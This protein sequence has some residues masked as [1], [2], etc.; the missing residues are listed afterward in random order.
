M[1]SFHHLLLAFLLLAA[2]FP[3]CKKEG[4]ISASTN[5]LEVDYPGEDFIINV[6]ASSHWTVVANYAPPTREEMMNHKDPVWYSPSGAYSVETGWI[7]PEISEGE[8]GETR[9]T[10]HIDA[11]TGKSRYGSLIFKLTED[12][13]LFILRVYQQGKKDKDMSDYLSPEMAQYLEDTSFGHILGI[14]TLYIR[15]VPFDFSRDL[16][17]FENLEELHCENSGLSAIDIEMPKLR[18]LHIANCKVKR[19]DPV[20]FPVLRDLDCSGNPL[21]SLDILSAPKLQKARCDGVRVKDLSLGPHLDYIT[22]VDCGLE[23]LDLS[24]APNLEDLDCSYN[25]L[26][27]LDISGTKITWL[28]CSYNER[29]SSLILQDECLKILLASHCGL[30]GSYCI[31]AKD[32][33][34]VDLQ[35]NKLEKLIFT[36]GISEGTIKCDNNQ[37]TELILPPVEEMGSWGLTCTNNLLHELGVIDSGQF[38][39]KGSDVTLNPGKDGIFKIYVTEEPD[40]YWVNY[41][42]QQWD[43]QGQGVSVQFVIIPSSE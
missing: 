28:D 5:I 15:D 3:S 26:I 25:N 40:N 39:W 24:R 22:L 41:L 29:L 30:S 16:V 13:Q 1:K 6:Q 18:V 33:M 9:L 20:L 35:N 38:S 10:V 8:G 31:S 34:F 23:R 27:E 32:L 42:H 37:L 19:L 43:W 4:T 2:A 7:I 11:T 12:G 17:Y 14:K 36:E 21:E